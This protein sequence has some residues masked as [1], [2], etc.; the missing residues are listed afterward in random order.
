M[1]SGGTAGRSC[2]SLNNTFLTIHI[3]LRTCYPR[4]HQRG[5]WQ[6]HAFKFPLCT[7]MH[8]L[9]WVYVGNKSEGHLQCVVW[10]WVLT[11]FSM[12]DMYTYGCALMHVQQQQQQHSSAA[13]IWHLQ[14]WWEGAST[15][16]A[17]TIHKHW[18]PVWMCSESSHLW[19]QFLCLDRCPTKFD[20]NLISSTKDLRKV[21]V[22]GWIDEATGTGHKS[23]R[24]HK[25]AIQR[26]QSRGCHS[27]HKS[28]CSAC[29]DSWVMHECQLR[30]VVQKSVSCN[31]I[32]ST[33]HVFTFTTKA[34]H[35]LIGGTGCLTHWMKLDKSDC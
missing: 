7:C 21:E 12:Y 14:Y 11:T 13:E 3:Y 35:A 27:D 4:K 22:R 24:L 8:M 2:L 15:A 23:N 18:R 32:G 25:P 30:H 20:C 9:V 31:D 16:D 10:T 1:C 26:D 5:T 17:V 34:M 6:R 19:V 29:A 33:K 28:V